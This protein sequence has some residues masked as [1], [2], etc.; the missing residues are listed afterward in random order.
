MERSFPRRIGAVREIRGFVEVFLAAE[1]I[2]TVNS[3]NLNLVIEELFTNLV[4]YNTDGPREIAVRL[5]HQGDRVRIS[6][7]DFDVKPFDPTRAPQVDTGRPLAERR[8]GGLGIHFVRE[9]AERI[10]YDYEHGNSRTTVVLRLEKEAD[11]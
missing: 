2:P 11:V 6:L 4:K 3:F 1:R 9:V 5:D 7:T 8:P 10:S